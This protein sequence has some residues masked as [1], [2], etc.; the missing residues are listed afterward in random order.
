VEPSLHA[1]G[2]RYQWANKLPVG[3]APQWLAGL[4]LKREPMLRS[5]TAGVVSGASDAALVRFVAASESGERNSRLYWAGR[6]A[7]EHGGGDEVFARL[8][9]AAVG[10]GLTA[11]EATLTLSSA[12]TGAV[13]A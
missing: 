10:V 3:V 2:H 13:A 9:A 6:R 8:H 5:V 7:A 1:S 4:M 11:H 12:R